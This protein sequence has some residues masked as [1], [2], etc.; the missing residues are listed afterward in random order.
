MKS[1]E[2]V[3]ISNISSLLSYMELESY[4]RP[5]IAAVIK[6]ARLLA[7]IAETTSFVNELFLF[8]ANGVNPP[9]VMPILPK[10]EKPQSAYVAMTTDL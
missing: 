1:Y 6:H 7:T 5:A 3:T 10:L 8:G 4:N 2:D 9:N